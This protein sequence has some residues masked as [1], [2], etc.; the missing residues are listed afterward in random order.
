MNSQYI[1]NIIKHSHIFLVNT[2]P[3]EASWPVPGTDLIIILGL[4]LVVIL[5]F[6]YVTSRRKRS[7]KYRPQEPLEEDKVFQ[8]DTLA[9]QGSPEWKE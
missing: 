4:V 1:E 8:G 2:F 5:I 7:A 6:F 3:K 9:P